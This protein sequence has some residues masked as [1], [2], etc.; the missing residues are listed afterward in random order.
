M[1]RKLGYLTVIFLGALILASCLEKHPALS[2]KTSY[3]PVTYDRELPKREIVFQLASHYYGDIDH[4]VGFVNSDGTRKKYVSTEDRFTVFEPIWKDDGGLL[5]YSTTHHI[6]GITQEGYGI[7]YRGK[8]WMAG[9]SP[10]HGKDEILVESSYEDRYAVKRIDLNSGK[11][12]EVYHVANYSINDPDNPQELIYLGTNSLHENELVFSR[13]LKDDEFFQVELTVYNTDTKE[14]RNILEFSDDIIPFREIISPAF[15][16]D[17]QWIAYT[18][19]DGIYLI[20]PDGSENHRIVEISVVNSLFWPPVASWSPD[21]Q[22]IVF[23]RCMLNDLDSCRN[24]VQDSSIFKYNINSGETEFIIEGGVNP[25]WRWKEEDCMEEITAENIHSMEQVAR[26]GI[27]YIHDVAVSPDMSILAVYMGDEIQIYDTETFDLLHSITAGNYYEHNLS[28]KNYKSKLLTFTSDSKTLVYSDGIGIIFWDLDENQR[29][30]SFSSLV[31]EWSVVDIALSPKEDRILVT[32]MGGSRRCDGRDMNYALYDLD[33]RLIFDRYMC[34]DYSNISY[35]FING[36]KLLL[37]NNSH[38]TFVNPLQTLL[39]DII[40]GSIL[41]QT[42]A[43]FLDYDE[44]IPDLELLYEISHDGELMA[45]A[46]YNMVD[47]KIKVH[48]KVIEIETKKVIHEQD[49]FVE[50]IEEE[51]EARW[52]DITKKEFSLEAEMG[53]CRSMNSNQI[54]T[55]DL[56]MSNSEKEIVTVTDFGQIYSIELWNTN[57]CEIEETISSTAA[58][59]TV[60]SPNGKWLASTDGYHAYLWEVETGDLHFSVSGKDYDKPIDLIQ[61][62]ADGSR[63]LAGSTSGDEDYP[64]KCCQI[65]TISVFDTKTGELI[66]EMKPKSDS[67]ED[68]IATPDN[69]LVILQDATYRHVLSIEAGKKINTLPLGPFAFSKQ[70]NLIW[71]ATQRRNGKRFFQKIILY[72]Y[73]TGEKIQEIDHKFDNWINNIF[74]NDSGTLLM[75]HYFT[76]TGIYVGDAILIFDLENEAI[77][78]L[79]YRLPLNY[80]NVSAIGDIFATSDMNGYVHLWN[81]ESDSSILT[82]LGNIQNQ[83]ISDTFIDARNSG[84]EYWI[85]G[86]LNYFEKTFLNENIFI[87]KGE[88]LSY[89]DNKNGNMLAEM[90]PD[91]EIESLI[92]SQDQTL[93]AVTGKDGII[94]L[95]GVV[96]EQ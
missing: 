70:D 88:S 84:N 21:G 68:I 50:F 79:S 71:I 20:H 22:W 10:I 53:I 55:Y 96:H 32:T 17:G 65:Y 28:K 61:F 6:E 44:P 46:V 8:H 37:V 90:R 54:F 64:D 76:G 1:R 40:Y 89:W 4:I 34:A 73:Y 16:P 12:L 5:L 93:I 69:D 81:Y 35:R 57:Y 58:N 2:I 47:E 86:Y 63:F 92:V 42:H 24:N 77:E 30:K 9:I 39:I 27:G 59:K 43:E 66:K 78:H 7:E 3:A 38:L 13:Y 72:N 87:T 60:F 36:D 51:G 56:L 18:S 85:S 62:N 52:R 80:S 25:F 91:Y 75:A 48:T 26:F 29:L 31:P 49:G 19:N 15:S 41:D 45:Y 67:L 83:N 11:V 82:F 33:G 94:R 14:S 23:H 95:W 74:L